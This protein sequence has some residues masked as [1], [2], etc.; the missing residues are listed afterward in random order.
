MAD[1]R[2]TPR[3]KRDLAD[4]W[5]TIAIDNESAADRLIGRFFD[6]FA[7]AAIHPEMGPPRPEIAVNA[8]LIIEGRYLAIYEPT[9]YGVLIVSVVHGARDP[10]RWLD[11]TDR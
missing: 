1:Y 2:L 7:L 5:R 8:R 3:A 9:L 10:S 6:K 4:I 11:D